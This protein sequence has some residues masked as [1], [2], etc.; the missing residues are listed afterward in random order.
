MF[1]HRSLTIQ[2]LAILA[3]AGVSRADSSFERDVRPVI[4]Q[5][6]VRC[7]GEKNP[8]AGI[9]LAKFPT[10]ASAIR[11][12]DLWI[13]AA[14]ALTDRSM[15]PSGKTQPDEAARSKASESIRSMLAAAAS[16]R[17]PGPG[18][19]QRLTREQ[20]NN[21][22]RDLLGID[23]RPADRFPADGG[24]GAGFDNNA[25]TLFVP[26]ILMEKYLDASS[27]A[28]N[29]AD[30]ARWKV[31]APNES[32]TP[33]QAARRN[34][35]AFATRAF[36]RPVEPGEIDRIMRVF[37][38]AT[39]SGRP[40]D[41]AMKA[42]L[43]AVLVSP[44]FL[45]I[46]EKAHPERKGP[47]PIDDFE[48]ASRLSYFLWSS[49]P[50]EAL[51]ALAAEG[52]LT[53]P[54]VLDAQ[55]KRMLLDPK[56][57]ALAEGFAGQWLG[58]N[59]LKHA[60]EPDRRVFP[61][62]DPA[63]RDAMIEEPIATFATVLQ[64][65]ASLLDL[66]DCDYVCVNERLARHYGMSGV[67]GPEFRKVARSGPDRGGLLGMAGVLTLTSYPQRT[68][69]VLRGRWVLDELLGT[70]PPPPPSDVKVLSPEDAPKDGKTFR[71]RLEFHRRNPGCAACHSKIDPPGFGLESFDPVG[72]VRDTIGGGPLDS[73]GTLSTGES[74]R[75][76][77]ELKVIL[78]ASKREIFA[79]NVTSRMLAY[80]LRRGVE[81]HDASTVRSIVESL[82][83][84]G[85]RS[86][87]LIAEIVKSYPFLNRRDEPIAEPSP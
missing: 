31:V 28:L 73:T 41:S 63:L 52:T 25:A 79:K 37:Q 65:D 61:E 5:F 82:D 22:L 81:F 34:L 56:A 77:A 33:D 84:N 48:L 43:K 57:R 38:K 87:V 58:V 51:F 26:P 2:S 69:P 1:T 59:S 45:F 20:Y 6:C 67:S 15:P 14:D 29:R 62:F 32:V 71:Q 75:G 24:G 47:Y 70:P 53:R 12:A 8:K 49:M 83:K 4:V 74:F 66:I 42:T 64:S 18:P 76:P 16:V 27:E 60:V 44:S 11:E 23:Y 17:D 36:R 30:L 68:S 86:T 3:I 54:D 7:H 40:F 46:A 85:Y 21:T 80:A 10:E 78:K 9:N 72:R 19:I 13:Q 35:I 55:V 39:A 50:D